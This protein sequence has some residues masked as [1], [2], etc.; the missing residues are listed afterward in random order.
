MT[1]GW[2]V[3]GFTDIRKVCDDPVG[4]RV[5]A[6]HRRSRRLVFITYLSPEFLTDAEFRYRF[7]TE[8]ARLTRVHDARVARLR[9][10]VECGED[11]AVVADRVPG[12]SLRDLLL[13]EGALGTDAALVVF[14][15]VL[16]ALA[17]GQAAGVAHGDLKPEGM[18]LT[19]AGGVR[20]VDFGLY[21]SPGRQL[22]ARSSPFYLAPELWTDGAATATADLYTATV[23][24]FECLVGAPPFHAADVASLGVLHRE[25]LPPLDAVPG[26]VRRLVRAGLAKNPGTR[27]DLLPFLV[28]IEDAAL[29]S[30]G[31][32]WERRGRRDLTR[33]LTVP[34]HPPP[35]PV[36]PEPRLGWE[37]RQ[38][39]RLAAA[40]GGAMALAA[41]LSSPAL[42]NGL[43]RM[44]TDSPGNDA[45][46]PVMAFPGPAD[47]SRVQANALQGSTASE[48]EQARPVLLTEPGPAVPAAAQSPTPRTG[49]VAPG[50]A[51]AGIDVQPADDLAPIPAPRSARHDPSASR[52]ASYQTPSSRSAKHDA[53]C[54]LPARDGSRADSRYDQPQRVRSDS[55]QQQ[56]PRRQADS[57][58]ATRTEQAEK[59]EKVERAQ[60]YAQKPER[61]RHRAQSAPDRAPVH[62]QRREPVPEVQSTSTYQSTAPQQ[63]TTS[64]RSATR[65]PTPSR[66]SSA[67]QQAASPQQQSPERLSAR[68]SAIEK[69]AKSGRT[70]QSGSRYG[71][72]AT[73]DNGKAGKQRPATAESSTPKAQK[74]HSAKP[75]TSGE[76]ASSPHSDTTSSLKSTGKHK[77]DAGS[78]GSSA[79]NDT[80]DP[81]DTRDDDSSSDKG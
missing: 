81:S 41:G 16:R 13:D 46:P 3:P 10:Y 22:L 75:Y 51:V 28:Q 33:L 47:N 70:P 68:Q 48:A 21:T 15:D 11:A 12:T 31:A 20:L 79:T 56:P 62:H 61:S 80:S 27:P 54:E 53:A 19:P 42:P 14:K 52:S 65:E 5:V 24:F 60:T 34:G 57:E 2:A 36:S 49:A 4:R 74:E 72:G 39:V 50:Q 59:T 71:S 9:R 23:T 78:R 55:Q 35:L 66:Y 25:G 73:T 1:S 8:S 40:L 29:D 37:R 38:P 69:M 18:I 76:H 67:P 44:Q 43:F 64:Q 63:S 26:P 30:R 58:Q 7:R 17:A 77:N 32:G 6:R 45:R